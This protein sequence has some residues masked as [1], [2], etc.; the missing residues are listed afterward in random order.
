MK[1]FLKWFFGILI[2]LIILIVAAAISLPYIIDPNDYKDQIIAQIK[3]HMLGRDLKIP[4]KI[5]LSVFPWLG[6]DIGDTVIGNADGFVL[7]PFITIKH[8]RA[9]IRLLS[10][11]S[12]TPEIGSLE[13][14][15][16]V[17]NLQRD[18]EGRN[19]WSDLAKAE[20]PAKARP[21]KMALT[22]APAAAA[23]A[24]VIPSLKV[25]GVH[26][27]DATINFDDRQAK[28]EIVI[29]KLNIDAGPL[30][31]L[32]PVPMKG[33]FNYYSKTQGLAAASAFA[34]TVAFVPESKF[35]TLQQFV[36]NTN[37]AGETLNNKT[38]TTSLKVPEF[39]IDLG[40]E[41]IEAKPFHLALNNMQ[42]DGRLSLRR[43]SNPIIQLGLDMQELDLDSLLPA[44]TK[45]AAPVPTTTGDQ[46]IDTSPAIFAALIPLKTADMQG[47]LTIKK[48][49]FNHLPFDNVR[50]NL[51]ARGGLLS[52]LPEAKLYQ[53]TYQG[54]LQIDVKKLPVRVR[55]KQELHN[56]PMGPITLALTGKE[57]L[58][59]TANIEGQFFSEG[60]TLDEITRQLNGDAVFNIRNVELTLMDV[61]QL[62][63]QKWYD[64]LKLADKQEAGKKVTA[65]DSMRGTIRVQNGIAY[66]H[67][68]S[69]VAQRVHLT[70]SGQANLVKQSVDYTL[71][72]IPK[73]SL[74]INLGNTRYDLKDKRIPTY[75]RGPWSNLDIKNDLGGM[76]K[77][78]VQS[79]V[80]TKKQEAQDKLKDRVEQEKDKLKDK[81]K[82]LL[83]R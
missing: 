55:L 31:Q 70:G 42:G 5:K 15:G 1:R 27:K 62:V 60:T 58:T 64:K 83:H 28:N 10:L 76:M 66:N 25:E 49:K 82:D 52:A 43:F 79:S 12:R 13:F 63:L 65:F 38:I 46:A 11:L 2:T 47:T 74:V 67:D 4:G 36:I 61:E 32:N 39:K 6:V 41:K 77:A 72:T 56:V 75:I 26:L 34:T 59:G 7:K 30:N 57:S 33:Q 51:L 53:G 9:H 16:V 24:M 20:A 80:D 3:P 71:I 35:I 73:K 68:F 8:S 18:A 14:D 48:L 45:P 40:Q 29:S 23:T 22:S 78:D 17:L 50:I 19:N 81:L 21:Q 54:D 44:H 37:V 69:A